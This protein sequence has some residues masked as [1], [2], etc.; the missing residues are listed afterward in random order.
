VHPD[1]ELVIF[2]HS[3]GTFIVS[4]ALKRML[5]TERL[6]PVRTIV[7]AGSVL[8]SR[9][10]WSF[11]LAS[12]RLRIVNECGIKDY[13]LCLCDALVPLLG[14]AG[15]T[16][17]HG[18]N[19]QNFVNRFFI[20]GHDLYFKDTS[21]FQRYWLPLINPTQP[22]PDVDERN[23]NELVN[24]FFEKAI[25]ILSKS[26]EVLYVIVIVCVLLHFIF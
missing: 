11:A 20:G 6:V 10:D 5:Q 19:N 2:C 9:F 23:P 18:I 21:F 7:L 14:M 13:V 16:G 3:F 17:F 8:P 12:K 22:I 24:G 1:K 4:N 26:K 15:R 25:S